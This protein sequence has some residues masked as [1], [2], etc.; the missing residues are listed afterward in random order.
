[1][2]VTHPAMASVDA[3]TGSGPADM[4]AR[5]D[6]MV[7]DTGAHTNGRPSMR[8]GINTVAADTA[9]GAD[10]TDMGACAH[11]MLADMRADAHAQ[12]I[13]TRADIGISRG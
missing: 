6:A 8:A 11:T 1:M 4:R 12:H 10:R 3:D 7:A 9:A 5:A 2:A 13:H